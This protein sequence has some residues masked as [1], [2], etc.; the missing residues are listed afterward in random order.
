M[1]ALGL[2]L[3][4]FGL[5]YFSLNPRFGMADGLAGDSARL[6]AAVIVPI[7]AAY[8]VS[9]IFPSLS[10]L[11]SQPIPRN[12]SRLISA[13]RVFLVAV[14]GCGLSL[15]LSV[16]LSSF[17]WWLAVVQFGRE[18]GAVISA[19]LMIFMALAS[20]LAAPLLGVMFAK[21]GPEAR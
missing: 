4:P 7:A 20:V 6:I 3:A 2:L 14:F 18:G 21:R 1:I 11:Q 5:A 15:V 16:L 17:V 13:S 12:T 10:F 8:S 9:V 19:L